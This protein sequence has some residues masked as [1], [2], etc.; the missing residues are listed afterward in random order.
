[1]TLWEQA[2][3]DNR[4]LL[5]ELRLAGYFVDLIRRTPGANMTF[6]VDNFERVLDRDTAPLGVYGSGLWADDHGRLSPAV[7][8]Q[9]GLAPLEGVPGS[10]TEFSRILR[11]LE[12]LEDLTRELLFVGLPP[13]Q[14]QQRTAVGPNDI[15]LFGSLRGRLGL[16][17]WSPNGS[18]GYTTAGHN[19]PQT[20]VVVWDEQG[21]RIGNVDLS[22]HLRNRPAMTPTADVALVE[23]NHADSNSGGTVKIATCRAFDKVRLQPGGLTSFIRGVSP[24]FAWLPSTASWGEVAITSEMI[25]IPGD[26]GAV[27]Y[28]DDGMAVGHVVAGYDPAYTLI[29]DAEYILTAVGASL[30]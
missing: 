19:A 17:V 6:S 2:L 29:Q 13:P 16:P 30:R 15:A 22:I 4:E 25:S 14:L 24:D 7:F 20:S 18:N 1:V 3:D 9:F 26:S 23:L 8:V 28:R 5:S 21:R 10:E 12:G 27:V 11:P